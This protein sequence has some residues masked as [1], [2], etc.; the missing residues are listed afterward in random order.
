[1]T[2]GPDI[3]PPLRVQPPR[4]PPVPR[5]ISAAAD[6]DDESVSHTAANAADALR[7]TQEALQ[8]VLS[9]LPGK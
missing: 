3:G 1:M 7:E 9:K 5:P 4:P 2:S 6:V 8:A